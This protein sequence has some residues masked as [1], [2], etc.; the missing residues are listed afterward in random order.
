M[1]DRRFG[2]GAL[3]LAC[4]LAVSA[5]G[6]ASA[7]PSASPTLAPTKAA[8]PL[9]TAS[10]SPSPSPTPEPDCGSLR[11]DVE[12][13][14][15]GNEAYRA[16]VDAQ[17]ALGCIVYLNSF[18]ALYLVDTASGAVQKIGDF[19]KGS[20]MYDIALAPDGTLY[21]SDEQGR[22][23]VSIDRW[24]AATTR[25]GRTASFVNGLT[26]AS[27]GRMYGSGYAKVFVV[28]RRIGTATEI[29]SLGSYQSAGDVTPNGWGYLLLSSAV[30]LR[31]DPSDG[32]HA[33]VGTAHFDT[34][35]GL[36]MTAAGLFGCTSAGEFLGID[37]LTGNYKVIA[38]GLPKC[39]GMG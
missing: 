28:D 39:Y 7:T 30:L 4:V 27:D 29:G 17:L 34:V 23:L 19:P 33:S 3:A 15:K 26:V 16:N 8:T 14:T 18:S 1:R 21:G 10:P 22:V 12:G 11:S 9:P 20:D 31:I 38:S 13:L 6:G 36:T 32:S 35:F 5:C 25:I 37:S 24:T 2:L